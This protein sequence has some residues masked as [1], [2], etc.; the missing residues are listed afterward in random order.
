[1][2]EV[3]VDLPRPRSPAISTTPEFTELKRRLL[4]PLL[5]LPVEPGDARE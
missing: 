2:L 1:V 4:G 3:D 5:G